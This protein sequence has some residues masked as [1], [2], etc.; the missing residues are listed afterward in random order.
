MMD[1]IRDMKITGP[2]TPEIRLSMMFKAGDAMLLMIDSLASW[3]RIL[4]RNPKTIPSKT[5]QTT[6]SLMMF[7]DFPS[8]GMLMEMMLHPIMYL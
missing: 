8:R 6:G 7:L 1:E 2:I 3:G 4:Q 5:P